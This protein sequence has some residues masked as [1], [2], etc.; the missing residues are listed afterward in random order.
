MDPNS[1]P[2]I[3]GSVT[4]PGR[5]HTGAE[6]AY[7]PL[8]KPC[9]G[10][11]LGTRRGPRRNSRANSRPNARPASGLIPWLL[12][13]ILGLS[14][15]LGGPAHGDSNTIT[16]ADALER[17]LA[18][19][20]ELQASR[21]AAEAARWTSRQAKGQLLPSL[22]LQSGFTRLDEETVARANALGTEF[23]MYFPDSSGQL[24]PVTIEIPQTVFRDG[25][26]TTLSAQW[27]LL[28]PSVWNTASLAGTAAG[29][30]R[31]EHEVARQR[32]IHQVISRYLDLLKAQ[33]AA[34]IQ[35]DHLALA[36]QSREQAERLYDVGRY[37]EADVL[38]WRVE[39][40]QQQ[41]LLV[42]Q[43]SA[44]H[45]A[46]LAL[47]NALGEMPLGHT[48]PVPEL[49]GPLEHALEGF[50]VQD[51]TAWH[52]FVDRSLEP[53]VK[54]TP[55]YTILEGAVR[56]ARLEH[57]Q[58]T[59]E[60]L[61]TLVVSGSYGWQEND[62]FEPDGEKAWSVGAT[63]NLPLFDGLRNVSGFQ[64]SDHRLA[65][66]RRTL[67]TSYRNMLL[68]A[69]SARTQIRSYVEQLGLAEASLESARRSFEIRKNS[70]SLGRLSNIEWID[71][72]LT[73]RTAEQNRTLAYYDLIQSI[74]DYHHAIGRIDELTSTQG[75]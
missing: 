31:A 34:T 63:L 68:A 28:N 39:E 56:S 21:H 55:A 65:E 17:A 49:P 8:S 52:D 23:T 51:E 27:L 59:Y 72:H 6:P 50:R 53:A 74:A 41:Q 7:G 13:L 15:Q 5:Q 16:L 44:R 26:R 9:R 66:A 1:S 43:E 24:R 47:E 57:R 40:A 73:L 18:N 35:R 14:G 36:R 32:T 67:E 70:F 46:A 42:R 60:F 58:S 45:I 33:E 25:Y 54:V 69:G 62:T 12:L 3:A 19:N 10:P 20:P 29:I 2:R 4:T 75:R 38:R 61:P 30:A 48:R 37:A 11:R 71:A 22:N 64:A